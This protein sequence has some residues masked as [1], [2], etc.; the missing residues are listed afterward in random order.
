M[1]ASQQP[2]E[3]GFPVNRI[4]EDF[5]IL[6]QRVHG[7]PLIYLDNA[8][9]SQKPRAVLQA[10]QNYYEQINSN[11][12]RG[13][14]TLSDQAT[15]AF[16]QAR[17][18]VARFL[19]APRTQEIIWTRGTTEALNLVAQ[20]FA[21]PRL[22]AGD[23]ILVSHLEHHSNIVPWQLVAAQTGARVIPVPVTE[24]GE[25][26]QTA[27]RS[28]LNERTRIVAVNHVSNALGTI[29]PIREMIQLAREAGAATVIDGAQA[30]PHLKVDVQDLGCDFYAFS[31]HKVGGPT[32]IGALYGRY[33]LLEAMPPWQGGGEMIEQVSFDGTTFN[34]P[35]FRFEAGTPAIAEAIGL[36]A[37]IDYFNRLDHGL[38]QQHE[39]SLLQAVSHGA[40]EISGLRPIGTADQK[41]SV[42]SFVVEGTHPSDLGTLLDHQGIAVRTGHHC[43]Q[44]LMQFFGVPGTVR[45]S[46][47]YYNTLE[48]VG[49]FLA[50]LKKA[51]LM[52][53]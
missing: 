22:K 32:G 47:S 24:Q 53:Q 14:H 45:A 37:A 3:K 38:L 51:I 16:E 50:G 33:A 2:L 4:R 48:E 42:F 40:R 13:A 7:K 11:V 12:H 43:T 46:F 31:G 36:G 8:A 35:P 28:L 20:S 26:D 5:P 44:P 27:Y 29:N 19:N 1:S 30:T 39:Q 15:A 34:Q 10:M 23:E 17:E 21:R 49:L 52:C 25:I 41:V 6:H 18:T 9:T